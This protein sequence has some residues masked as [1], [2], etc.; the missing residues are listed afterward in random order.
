M[1]FK[2]KYKKYLE[3]NTITIPYISKWDL[4][5]FTNIYRLP[6]LF[7]GIVPD[8]F[9]KIYDSEEYLL[10]IYKTLNINI[11]GKCDEYYYYANLP[12]NITIK[13]EI[14]EFSLLDGEKEIIDYFDYGNW[15]DREVKVS[16]IHITLNQ[17]D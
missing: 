4:K 11:L 16:E 8:E 15:W 3:E 7:K 2:E 13:G 10:E 14:N 17:V 6:I 9:R 12:E 1:Y 5:E